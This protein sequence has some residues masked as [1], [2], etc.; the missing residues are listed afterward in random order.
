MTVKKFIIRAVSSI[1][2]LVTFFHILSILFPTGGVESPIISTLS[3]LIYFGVTN[4]LLDWIW[5]D[6]S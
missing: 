4:F 3:A 5:Q 2:V 6:K 1:L